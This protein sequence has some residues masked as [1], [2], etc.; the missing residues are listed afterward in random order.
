MT[1]EN[2]TA[3]IRFK[4]RYTVV[5][6]TDA[7]R[8]SRM[9]VSAFPSIRFT[10]KRAGEYTLHELNPDLTL[11]RLET[12]Y[13]KP[14]HLHVPY[15]DSMGVPDC[16]DF[17]AWVEPED[18]QPSW[19]GPGHLDFYWIENKPEL[20]FDLR[21]SGAYPSVTRADEGALHLS[22]HRIEASYY[23]DQPDKKRFL[24]KV[25][26]ILAKMT[27]NKLLRV[28]RETREP[29][30]YQA[31]SELCWAGPDA[32]RWALEHPLRTFGEDIRPAGPLEVPELE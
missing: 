20:A 30:E 32:I 12:L 10:R 15:V 19:G 14:P 4:T 31:G 27:T 3:G 23:P 1:K 2:R 11:K 6:P 17:T 13:F 5:T 9:L 29:L 25:W 26:R 28:D 21:T 24:D 16:G 18:W 7:E 8:F 22:I